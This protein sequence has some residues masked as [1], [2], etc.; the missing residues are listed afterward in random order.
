VR[1]AADEARRLTAEELVTILAHDLRN[2]LTAARGRLGLVRRR[3]QRYDDADLL[4]SVNRTQL[5]L[6]RISTMVDDLLDVARLER[7]T[8]AVRP[9]ETDLVA[10][11]RTTIES[12]DSP[13][14]IGLEAPASLLAIVDAPRVRQA[15]ENLLRNAFE[16]TEADSA[17]AVKLSAETR[18]NGSWARIAVENRGEPVPPQLLDHLVRPFAAGAASFGVGLGLYIVHGIVL[19]HGGE[20]SVTSTDVTSFQ[21]ALPAELQTFAARPPLEAGHGDRS[22]GPIMGDTAPQVCA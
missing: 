5:A 8:F 14:E 20:L 12:L 9:E 4:M 3:T 16:H 1:V 2:H 22:G 21:I 17:V 18:P 19:A 7:G 13:H 6:D 10:L 15:L 11:A